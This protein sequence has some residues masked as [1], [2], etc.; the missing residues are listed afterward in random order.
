MPSPLQEMEDFLAAGC[1]PFKNQLSTSGA[2]AEAAAFSGAWWQKV[3]SSSQG[4]GHT[5]GF[6]GEQCSGLPPILPAKSLFISYFCLW[7]SLDC[8]KHR[9]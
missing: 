7:G 4:P 2:F 9:Q 3:T 8:L 6:S 5:T 1:V